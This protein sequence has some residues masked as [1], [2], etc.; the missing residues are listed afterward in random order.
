MPVA[1]RHLLA[2]FL[3]S[4]LNHHEDLLAASDVEGAVRRL[5]R[6]VAISYDIVE[7][8]RGQVAGLRGDAHVIE[9]VGDVP[10]IGNRSRVGG[11][12]PIFPEAIHAEHPVRARILD[13]YR[14]LAWESPGVSLPLFLSNHS[15]ER[16]DCVYDLRLRRADACLCLV[17]HV[18]YALQWIGVIGLASFLVTVYVLASKKVP[19]H[20]CSV[21]VCVMNSLW[22]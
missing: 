15:Q 18:K 8:M 4:T 14:L 7:Q 2:D 13:I 19:W 11:W 20:F 10:F 22:P 3:Q 16:T 5:V 17:E 12:K 6:P 9:H 1:P 21:H